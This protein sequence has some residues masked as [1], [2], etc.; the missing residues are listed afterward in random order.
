MKSDETGPGEPR[1]R[2]EAEPASPG[3]VPKVVAGQMPPGTYLVQV[4]PDAA[5]PGDPAGA[6]RGK[7]VVPAEVPRPVPRG[8][9]PLRGERT[10][11]R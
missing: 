1:P 3:A 4:V 9:N 8:R 10:K 11:R 5:A 6:A 7:P 2:V